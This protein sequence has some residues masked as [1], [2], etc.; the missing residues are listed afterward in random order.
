MPQYLFDVSLRGS[1]RIEGNDIE[2]AREWLADLLDCGTAN[3]GAAHDGSPV[4]GEVSLYDD[5]PPVFI[6]EDPV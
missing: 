6:P 5:E 3:F 1:I 4:I 2:Q